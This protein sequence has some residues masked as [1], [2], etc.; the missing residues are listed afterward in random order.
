[1][2]AGAEWGW[3]GRED[4]RGQLRRN[5]SA[6][7]KR[8]E[9]SPADGVCGCCALCIPPARVRPSVRVR[10]PSSAPPS[11][12]PLLCL[13]PPLASLVRC[14]P[15]RRTR[16]CPPASAAMGRRKIEIQ[17]ITVRVPRYGRGLAIRRIDLPARA[18]LGENSP[19]TV[20][21][22]CIARTKQVCDLFEGRSL[23]L[24]SWLG[25]LGVDQSRPSHPPNAR[26]P[27]GSPPHSARTASSRKPTSSA[28][29][30]QSTSP[31][32]SS[33]SGQVTMSSSSSTARQTS[34][35]WSSVIFA[36]V[37]SL[38]SPLTTLSHDHHAVRWRARHTRAS[39]LQRKHKERQR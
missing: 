6:G 13:L 33:R 36:C 10:P 27:T 34:I 29:S 19:L 3:T 39:R 38:S 15:P 24:H 18:L 26:L 30:A 2:G 32:S 23:F 11:R 25:I 4:G 20:R 21:R 14:S 1:M 16:P 5:G 31:S 7:E 35:A 8:G 37:S 17:P 12:R 9:R 28:S 22:P